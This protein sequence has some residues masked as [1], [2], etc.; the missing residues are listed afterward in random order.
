MIPQIPVFPS[1][2][3]LLPS[4]NVE[5]RITQLIKR[6]SDLAFETTDTAVPL[7]NFDVAHH[8]RENLLLSVN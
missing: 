4:A 1:S 6:L 5:G 2:K 8:C 7:T 3:E